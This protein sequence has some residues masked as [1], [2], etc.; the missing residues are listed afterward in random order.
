MKCL[1]CNK[2]LAN[3]QKK[4]CSVQC[5]LEYQRKIKVQSWLNGE[6]DGI[7]GEYGLSRFIR[8]YL[9]QKHSFKCEICGWGEINPYTGTLPLEIHHKDGNYKNNKEDNLQVLCP[10]CHSLT[11][12]FKGA[13]KTGR[14][15]REKYSS[16]KNFCI[17]CGV[18]IL[19]TSIR[20]KTCANKKLITEK[21]VTR[22]KLK[23]LIRTTPF[24][25]IGKQYNVSDNAIRK[26]CL[27][28]NL[29]TK[30]IDIKKYTDEEWKNL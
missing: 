21:P 10:N 15:G 6:D 2:E 11:E 23:E 17:D 5:Q 9:L 1:N 12:H 20:C 19:P 22:E 25:T 13:N 24:T 26:W 3:R 4:Y 14:E 29:P 7:S 28:Y 8:T 30:K 18:E 16:R 27:Q